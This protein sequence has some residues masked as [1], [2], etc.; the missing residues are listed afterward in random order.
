MIRF[1]RS[2]S[3]AVL[4]VL[5]I[6]AIV[7]AVPMLAHP[8]GE[9]WQMPQSILVRSPF[10][11]FLIPGLILLAM[12]G[13]LSLLVLAFTFRR[14]RNYGFWIA[15]QGCI[16][17]SWLT[18]ECILIRMVIWPHYMYGALGLVLVVCGFVLRT[19]REPAV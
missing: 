1:I 3:I 17:L 14:R 19:D 10:D 15:A 6:S 9:P 12:N 13:L 8:H 4:F 16:L 11:S 2:V 18:V 7:G 5:G